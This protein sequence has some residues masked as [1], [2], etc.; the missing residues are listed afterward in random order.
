MTLASGDVGIGVLMEHCHGILDGKAI[1]EDWATS[2]AIPIFN[3][4]GDIMNCGMIKGV[5]ILEHAMKIAENV[6]EKILR[7]IATIDDMQ[8]GFMPDKGTIDAVF[9]WRRIQEEYLYTQKKLCTWYID[10]EKAFDGVSRK[11]VEWAMRKKGITVALGTA[12]M[13][14]YKGTRTKV[15]VGAHFSEE[16]EVDVGV[17]QGSV[18]SPLLLFAIVVDVVT[19]EIK[20]GMSQ[21]ILSA[22]DMFLIAE[23][24]AELPENLMIGKAHLS[25]KAWKCIWWRQR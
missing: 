9:I 16:F 17:H 13:S 2:V 5:R 19:N 6:L 1:P 21:K 10:Q 12:V 7:K 3:G 18:L 24:M 4:K 11:V 22:D 23:I 14:L 25:V 20:E 8:F 15:K